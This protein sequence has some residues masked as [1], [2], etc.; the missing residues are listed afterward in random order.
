MLKLK[1]ANLI[2]MSFFLLNEKLRNNIVFFFTRKN[3]K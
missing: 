1:L 3:I 2:T